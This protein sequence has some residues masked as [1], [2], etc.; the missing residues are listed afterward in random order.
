MNVAHSWFGFQPVQ[1]RKLEFSVDHVASRAETSA[2][3]LDI[4]GRVGQ[5]IVWIN[6][7]SWYNHRSAPVKSPEKEK[8]RDF[9]MANDISSKIVSINGGSTFTPIERNNCLEP[10]AIGDPIF[11]RS[12]YRNPGRV[13]RNFAAARLAVGG[14]RSEWKLWS[15]PRNFSPISNVS[16]I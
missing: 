2:V 4:R 12:V 1:A 14:V 3:V 5:R 11:E 13:L 15:F 10:R 16:E 7:E 8:E 6:F 9:W